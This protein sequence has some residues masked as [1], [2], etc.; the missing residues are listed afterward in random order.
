[1]GF[2]S[3]NKE[4]KSN[5]PPAPMPPMAQGFNSFNSTPADISKAMPVLNAPPMPMRTSFDDIKSQVVSMPQNNVAQNTTP[6]LNV[7]NNTSSDVDL[8]DESLFDFSTLD[9]PES[10]SIGSS[11]S[12]SSSSSSAGAFSQ[13]DSSSPDIVDSNLKNDSNLSFVT[14]RNRFGKAGVSDNIYVTTSQFKSFIELVEQVRVRVKESSDKHL[15]LLDIKSEEDQEYEAL[16]KDFQFIED[17][18]YEVDNLI[19]DK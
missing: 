17:K 9:I 6:Q 8:N 19:F 13:K 4:E 15:R 7:G 3:K 12:S 11:K 18:L 16:R 2:F 1:M 10:T 5:L 14:N